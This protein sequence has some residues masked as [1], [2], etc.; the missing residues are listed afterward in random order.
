MGSIFLNMLTSPPAVY[1]DEDP[2]RVGWPQLLQY[3]LWPG[4]LQAFRQ[5]WPP[6]QYEVPYRRIVHDLAAVMDMDARGLTSH[7]DHSGRRGEVTDNR[8]ARGG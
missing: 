3:E 2:P 4:T 6:L 1:S 8:R 5:P 7:P